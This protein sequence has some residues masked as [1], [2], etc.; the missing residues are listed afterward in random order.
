MLLKSSQA[1]IFFAANVRDSNSCSLKA[2]SPSIVFEFHNLVPNLITLTN[3]EEKHL[4]ISSK[5][6]LYFTTARWTKKLRRPTL[7]QAKTI[8]FSQIAFCKLI[9]WSRRSPSCW[10]R[11]QILLLISNRFHPLN[12][13]QVWPHQLWVDLQLMWKSQ[14]QRFQQMIWCRKEWRRIRCSIWA[15]CHR[16]W[17]SRP[18]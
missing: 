6:V 16:T 12:M 3:C 11:N 17:L 9:I 13:Y 14:P 8:R 5:I 2:L 10:H 1:Q 18:R 4:M 15:I 7:L